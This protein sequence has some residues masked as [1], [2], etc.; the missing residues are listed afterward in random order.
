MC[1]HKVC[2]FKGSIHYERS[3]LKP[4][5]IS[6]LC[7]TKFLNNDIDDMICLVNNDSI[8]VLNYI[9]VWGF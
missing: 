7:Y 1:S 9:N 8:L 5:F 2:L 3:F 6:C 4:Y